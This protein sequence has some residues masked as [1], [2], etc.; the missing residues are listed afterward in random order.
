MTISN[1]IQKCVYKSIYKPILKENIDPEIIDYQPN[2]YDINDG[3]IRI[4]LKG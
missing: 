2:A 1:T 4:Y 3:I